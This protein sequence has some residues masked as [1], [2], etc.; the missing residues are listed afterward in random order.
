MYVVINAPD[1]EEHFHRSVWLASI[2]DALS[3]REAGMVAFR[4]C[5][6]TPHGH[7]G[8]P[9]ELND[10]GLFTIPLPAV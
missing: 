8:A 4:Y 10:P 9:D 1:S 3:G 7:A 5:W 6:P 2:E